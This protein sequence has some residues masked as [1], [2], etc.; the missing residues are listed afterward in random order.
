MRKK[1]QIYHSTLEI[2]NQYGLEGVTISKISKKARVSP[3]IIYHY[4]NTK[5]EIIQDL[6]KEIKREFFGLFEEVEVLKKPI[7]DCYKYAWL[8]IFQ[9]GMENPEKLIF[10]EKYRNS[11]YKKPSD[12]AQEF[13]FLHH[14]MI[15]SQEEIEK[16][17][18]KDLPIEALYTM[19]IGVAIEFV[20]MEINGIHSFKNCSIEAV[21]ES[22]CQSILNT[23]EG[24][25]IAKHK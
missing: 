13:E 24:V 22:I 7:L 25:A 2:I 9:Y 10:L 1:E 16:G 14:L 6:A 4:F 12:V 18:L 20:K 3:G 19:T 21:A 23:K 17:V 5:E 15:K 11:A 8:E